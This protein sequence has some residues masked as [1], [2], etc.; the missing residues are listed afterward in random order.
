MLKTG[1]TNGGQQSS[2]WI[3]ILVSNH[4]VLSENVASNTLYNTHLRIPL[5]LQLP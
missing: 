4:F 1:L 2:N 3:S 5:V